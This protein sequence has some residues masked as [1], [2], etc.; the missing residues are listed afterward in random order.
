MPTQKTCLSKPLSMKT[1][2]LTVPGLT[3]TAGETYISVI[4][5]IE[6]L[7]T[8]VFEMLLVEL[9]RADMSM[10]VDES[11][12]TTQHYTTGHIQYVPFFLYVKS[13]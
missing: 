3:V 2:G 9:Q 12:E 5:S 10:A 13:F 4:C 6:I 1:T 11:A 8:V 7:N